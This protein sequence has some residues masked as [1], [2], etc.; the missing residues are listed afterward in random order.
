MPNTA[1]EPDFLQ[2]AVGVVRR[3]SQVLIA[4]CPPL[5]GAAE[6]W[7]FPGGKLEAGETV[8]GALCR[9]LAEELAIEVLK[10][11]PWLCFRHLYPKRGVELH[12]WRVLHFSG[13]PR[14]REGQIVRWMPVQQ[15]G[16]L[17][18]HAGN[19][20]ILAGLQREQEP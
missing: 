4:R 20:P 7:E 12:V 18:F 11:S 14:G 6:L 17:E 15:L 5:P 3:D 16:E 19:R 10:A 9:E 8:Y 1:A 13:V 2:V